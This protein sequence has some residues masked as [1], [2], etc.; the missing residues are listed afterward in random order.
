MIGMEGYHGRRGGDHEHHEDEPCIKISR[1]NFAKNFAKFYPRRSH[2]LKSIY[3]FRPLIVVFFSDPPMDTA[4][5]RQT[6]TL[7]A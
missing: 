5:S 3:L 6:R 1:E 2:A 4:R 7:H